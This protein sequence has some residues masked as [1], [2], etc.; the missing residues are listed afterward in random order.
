MKRRLE[1]TFSSSQCEDY[2]NESISKD[3][4]TKSRKELLE[5]CPER[6]V[7][8][9]Y[10][11]TFKMLFRNNQKKDILK[12]FLN[13]L[14]GFK[15]DQEIKEITEIEILDSAIQNFSI[16]GVSCTVDVRCKTKVGQEVVVEMQRSNKEYFLP[17]MQEYMGLML[18][19]QV[20]EGESSQY[21]LKLCDSYILVIAKKNIFVD[22]YSIKTQ[23]G[24]VDDLYEKTVVPY[25]KELK[26]EIPGNKMHWKFFELS[27]FENKMKGKRFAKDQIKEQWLE[28]LIRC[29]KMEEVPEEVDDKIKDAYEMM[30]NVKKNLNDL[31]D[32]WVAKT[33]EYDEQEERKALEEKYKA[34]GRAEGKIEGKIENL[35]NALVIPLQ[36]EVL[37]KIFGSTFNEEKITA[38]E[39]YVSEHPT[40]HNLEDV[41]KLLLGGTLHEAGS[42]ESVS[43][44]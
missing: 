39:K 11:K 13:N 12:S 28:F 16:E 17:R 5:A 41:S 35:Y 33:K 34:E 40:D 9:T 37:I 29:P 15:N 7:D 14:L 31:F 19:G 2:L 4:I 30:E 10:D 1:D 38:A 32:Y 8:P 22:K 24:G 42:A 21:H 27:R 6:F 20:K 3:G 26:Q 36:H 23:E 43:S 18:L 44:S 25:I